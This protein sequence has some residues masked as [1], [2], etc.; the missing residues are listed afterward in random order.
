MPLGGLCSAVAAIRVTDCSRVPCRNRERIM[1]A[2]TVATAVLKINSLAWKARRFSGRDS[3][4][5]EGPSLW[6]HSVFFF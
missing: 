3:A 2:Q 1:Q 5:V 4:V 6:L